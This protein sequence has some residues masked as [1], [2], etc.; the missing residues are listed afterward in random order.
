MNKEEM[1]KLHSIEIVA[2]GVGDKY[3]LEEALFKSLRENGHQVNYIL[4]DDLSEEDKKEL[5]ENVKEQCKDISFAI[6]DI[7]LPIPIPT[8]ERMLKKKCE[9]Q[10]WRKRGKNTKC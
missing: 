7:K 1:K 5:V 9:N 10:P 4:I 6:E 8:R 3:F 2:S